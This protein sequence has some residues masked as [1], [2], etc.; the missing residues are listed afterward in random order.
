M[1]RPESYE[2][3]FYVQRDLRAQ[4]RRLRQQREAKRL[5]EHLDYNFKGANRL[6]NGFMYLN[7]RPNEYIAEPE[8]MLTP[9]HFREVYIE[10]IRWFQRFLNGELKAYEFSHSMPHDHHGDTMRGL[11]Q[12]FLDH[13]YD[14]DWFSEQDVVA[15]SDWVEHLVRRF[16]EYEYGVSDT[17]EAEA[18]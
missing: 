8:E 16:D 9:K 15:I 14:P 7:R 12:S 18:A 6:L 10:P 11:I 4:E 5:K 2:S 1:C 17:Q 3:S 13:R